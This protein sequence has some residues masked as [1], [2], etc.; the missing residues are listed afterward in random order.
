MTGPDSPNNTIEKFAITGTDLGIMWDNGDPANHQVLMAFG[1]T[2]GYC[3]VRGQQWRYN[4]LMRSQDGALSNTISVPN[5]VVGNQYSGSPLWAPGLSKQII[6]STKWA[7]S[8]TGII[9]DCRHCR[10]AAPSTSTSCP[11]RAGTPTA[12]GRRTSRRSPCP[13]TTANAGASTP[14]PSAWHDRT[15]SQEAVTFQEMRT[16]NRERS[17]SPGRATPTSTR[18]GHRP[19]AAVRHTSRAFSRAMCRT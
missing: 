4:T 1:D 3:G 2:Y 7:P 13:P 10:R 6:N 8:E 19:V 12:H 11:S 5:G 17:S 15:P 14:T 16:S 9:P 18:S